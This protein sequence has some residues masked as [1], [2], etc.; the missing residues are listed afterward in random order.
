MIQQ[1]KMQ[2]VK[3]N[4]ILLQSIRAI[5]TDV[6]IIL[7]VIFFYFIYTLAVLLSKMD[8]FLDFKRHNKYVTKL[9]NKIRR[10]VGYA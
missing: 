3:S 10:Y 7:L 8:D 9:K 6:Y 5:T 1:C 4:N 2:T